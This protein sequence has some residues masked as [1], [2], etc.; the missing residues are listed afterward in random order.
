MGVDLDFLLGKFLPAV[1][2]FNTE[3]YEVLKP[4]EYSAVLYK[5]YEKQN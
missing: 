3:F 2:I 5:P 1:H 4:T